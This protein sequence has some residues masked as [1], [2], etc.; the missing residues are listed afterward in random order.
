M[1]NTTMKKIC[2]I[3]AAGMMLATAAP[4]LAADCEVPTFQTADNRT[5]EG[6]MT[7]KAGKSC[8]VSMGTGAAGVS[9]P[10]ILKAPKNG[11]ARIQGFRAVYTP[12]KGFQGADS[13]TYTRFQNDRWGNRAQRTVDMKVEVVP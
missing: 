12:K 8:S 9:D 3:A 10:A 2:F 6:R 5:V 7:V 11:S 1:A 13:F 4:V